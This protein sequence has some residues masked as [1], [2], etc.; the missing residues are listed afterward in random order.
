MD[1]MVILVFPHPIAKKTCEIL[2]G[3]AT[4]EMDTILDAM[5]EFV[6]II[7]GRVKSLLHEHKIDVSITLPRTYENVNG[8]LD[9]VQG[10]KGVQVDLKF[11]ND[12]FI[13]F[14]TR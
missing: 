11:E 1:G 12:K 7:G 5:A 8:L 6:N 9:V 10:K 4:D 2:I 14:L 13:F 3:E